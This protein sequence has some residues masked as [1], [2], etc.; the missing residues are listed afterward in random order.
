MKI[1]LHKRGSNQHVKIKKTPT[2]GPIIAL[3]LG[4]IVIA[5]IVVPLGPNSKTRLLQQ[6][7][8]GQYPPVVVA[9]E[10]H[11]PGSIKEEKLEP[12]KANIV[13]YI[14]EVFGKYGTH[15]GVQA[16]ECFYS[17]SGLRAEAVNES[18]SNGTIDRGVAQINSVHG[19]SK[20]DAH[21]F[22]KNIDMAEKVF[23]RAGKSFRPWYGSRCN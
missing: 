15:I 22:R 20:E 10:V 23:L 17:E 3:T 18:N 21:D 9:A 11:L 7:E 12:T 8:F 5:I 2:V 16:I 1:F 19:M 13:A 14:M 4:L 6:F